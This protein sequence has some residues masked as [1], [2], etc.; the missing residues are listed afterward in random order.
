MKTANEC[1]PALA[2]TTTPSTNTARPV[3]AA[4]LPSGFYH[5]TDLSPK[6]RRAYLADSSEWWRTY[7]LAH[8]ASCT[9]KGT[10]IKPSPN[11]KPLAKRK[12]AVAINDIKAG[13]SVDAVAEKYDIYSRDVYRLWEENSPHFPDRPWLQLEA[14]WVGIGKELLEGGF[15]AVEA[16]ACCQGLPME[17]VEEYAERLRSNQHDEFNFESREW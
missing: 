15:D 3:R 10:D 4:V 11:A 13:S 6:L 12:L 5:I 9:F 17:V 16:I 1:Q 7:I 14:D 8:P 2:P